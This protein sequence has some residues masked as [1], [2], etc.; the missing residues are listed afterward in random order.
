MLGIEFGL[1][2]FF[3]TRLLLYVTVG[4][5]LKALA[6]MSAKNLIFLGGS[7]RIVPDK[8]MIDAWLTQPFIQPTPFLNI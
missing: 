6:D 2:V 5:G 3:L 1:L 7:P 4:G 8:F